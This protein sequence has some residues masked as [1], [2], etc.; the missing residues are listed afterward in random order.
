L[1]QVR[2]APQSLT[3][4]AAY[5][6]ASILASRPTPAAELP[7]LM[8][9]VVTALRQ[10][11]EPSAAPTAAWSDDASDDAASDDADDETPERSGEPS[12]RA[13][14]PSRKMRRR[15]S[16]SPFLAAEDHEHEEVVPAAAPTLLRRADVVVAVAAPTETFR[17]PQGAVRGIV[18]WFDARSR[19]G[20]LRV[21]GNGSDVP[22]EPEQ[23][24]EA[25]ITRLFKGQEVEAQLERSGD[26]ISLVRLSLP[27]GAT[28]TLPR[29][30]TVRGRQAKPVVV[31]LKRESLRRAAAREEAEQL[32]RPA[33]PR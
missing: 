6:I 13:R 30:G 2:A 32:L 23:L 12:D 27:G 26:A 29:T 10:I 20:A 3:S 5:A 17:A 4:N 28:P 9:K 8:D 7:E 18:K 31:E 19:R 1:T 25:G 11:A 24:V 21:P 33:R 15:R 22:V 16:L 14:R